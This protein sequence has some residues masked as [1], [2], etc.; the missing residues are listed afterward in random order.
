MKLRYSIAAS[1]MA[2]SAATVIAAPAQAQQITTG[3]QGQVNDDS[4]AA[5]AGATVVIT[6][7]RTGASRT[8]TTGAD[9]RFTTSGLTTGGPYTISANADSYEGQSVTDVFTTLQ[10]NT[11]LSF[12]LSSGG[13]EIVVTGTRVRV[14]QLEVGPGTSFTTEVLASAPSF[15]RDVRDIIR[16]DPRVSLDR[17]DGGSGQDRISCLG[18]NDRGNAFTVDGISQGDVYGLND[19]GFSSRSSTPLPYDAV[20]ETQVQFA[21]FDVDYGS[22]TGCAINVVTKSGTNDYKFGGFFEYSDNGMRGDKLP[23]IAQLPPI[24]ADKRWGVWAGGPIIKDRLFIFGAYEHQEA[25]QS[26]DDGPVGGGYANE[27]TGITVDQ[28]NEISQVLRDVYGVDTGPLVTNRPFKNDRYFGRLDWQINDDHRLELTYQRLEEGSTRA[29]DLFTGTSPQAIG[30]NTFYTSGTKSDYYSGRLY[31]QWTDNF[32]T[33]LRYSRSEVTDRQDPIGGGE[34]QSA[35]P[36][37]RIIVGIDN[38]TGIDGAILAGPGNS[39]SANDLRTNIDQY[40]AVARLVSGAHELK[41]GVE[42][43][44][45]DLFNL[46]VQNATGTLVFRNIN[47]L[48]AGLLSPGLGNNQTSTTAGNVISGQTEGAF[49]N[50]S[51]TGDVNDAAAAFKRDIYTIFAQDDWQVSD[52]LSAVIGV[53]ADWYGG[54]KPALNSVFLQRYGFPNTTGFSN[55]DPVIMPRLALT[56]DMDDF[57]VFG[58]PKLTAGVGIFSG[59]DPVVWFG[60]AFQNDGRGFATGST[61]STNCPTGQVSVLTGGQFTGVPACIQADGVN[62]AARGLGDTQSISPDIKMPTVLRA[63]IGFSSELNF[64]PSGFFS[65]WNLNL[66]YIYSKYRDPLTIVDLS[67]TVDPRL[68]V[69]G[70]TIDGRPIYRSIDPNATGCNA[71]L[72]GLNPGPV[73]TGVTA[74]CFNTSRDDELQLTNAGSYR[75]HNASFILSKTFNGGLFTENGNVDFNVGYAYTDS[76]DRRSMYNSTAGSNYDLVAAFD[77]QNPAASRGFYESRHNIST[78]LAFR[79]EFFEDLSTRFAISFIARSGRPYSLTFGGTTQFNDSASGSDNALAYLPTGLTDPNVSP[80]STISAAN[81][82]ALVD[83]INDTGCAKK[84]IGTTVPRN[85]CSNDWYFDMDLSFSQEIPGP[86]RLFG[87]NDKLKLYATMDNFLNFLDSG[88]NVQNRRN[89]AGLQDIATVSG[90]DA[91]G[92]YIFTGFNGAGSIADDNGINVSSSVWRLKVGVSYEF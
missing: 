70:L 64:A 10:G 7:T 53:R 5:I 74:A 57:A 66:D 48:R 79:E 78:R 54:G 17:D 86:G 19:T 43:N 23:G 91:Q 84:Y 58:R 77:R 61:Q 32:S 81:M 55:L 4:G 71:E 9:G 8:I 41:V 67:Q 62:Q 35:N 73:F 3:I 40:R 33:E 90:V 24:K 68:G 27:Q 34:A 18:G 72:V 89:F 21:P 39:R 46:F 12:A 36:I 20:R 65:G 80:S 47:D 45:A 25:G 38:P 16:L 22:F 14:T 1:L 75:S 51:A 76:Q 15:N 6:D 29:D 37:P 28:F 60:N 69:N 50:F 44:R 31:S 85:T 59:G 92:R 88:W 83:Y 42:M 82:Q 2:I 49:G 56:Y 30:L 63:N 52:R 87:R 13:G 11:S 26:Q